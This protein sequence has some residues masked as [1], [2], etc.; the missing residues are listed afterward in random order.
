MLL[1]ALVVTT[2]LKA[3]E[4]TP[5]A[6]G[7]AELLAL[8]DNNVAKAAERGDADTA[9]KWATVGLQVRAGRY[10]GP[11]GELLAQ[12]EPQLK[13]LSAFI[14]AAVEVEAAMPTPPL[15]DWWSS[16]PWQTRQ[17]AAL[18]ANDPQAWQLAGARDRAWTAIRRAVTAEPDRYKAVTPALAF[19]W[20][21]GG[22]DTAAPDLTAMVGPELLAILQKG[23]AP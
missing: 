18:L 4:P 2:R 8:V 14:R 22:C 20:L 7:T 23:G 9:L 11:L 21:E 1:L 13:N 6:A 17:M 12:F 10:I 16:T 19:G 15:E 3:G 5:P